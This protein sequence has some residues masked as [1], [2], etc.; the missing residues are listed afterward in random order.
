MCPKM[1]EQWISAA[2]SKSRALSESYD[3]FKDQTKE[4]L[5][6]KQ[7]LKLSPQTS[8]TRRYVLSVGRQKQKQSTATSIN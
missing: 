2:L 4:T 7:N 8:L 1:T 3:V 5:N 6:Y